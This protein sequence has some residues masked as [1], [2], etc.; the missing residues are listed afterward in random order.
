[1]AS[2][3]QGSILRG[4]EC[5]GPSHGFQTDHLQARALTAQQVVLRPYPPHHLI[6]DN[7]RERLPSAETPRARELFPPHGL[8]LT[9]FL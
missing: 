3:S 2:A 4:D 9:V 1:M 8:P 5:M 7:P 6:P